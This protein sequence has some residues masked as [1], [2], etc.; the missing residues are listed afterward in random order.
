MQKEV[1]KK[2]KENMENSKKEIRKNGKMNK[3]RKIKGDRREKEINT[4]K[5][6]RKGEKRK[7]KSNIRSE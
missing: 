6:R 1:A 3:G 7:M 5:K 2:M 4:R